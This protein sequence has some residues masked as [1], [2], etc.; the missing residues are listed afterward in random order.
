MKGQKNHNV[1]NVIQPVER[2]TQQRVPSS[3]FSPLL[4]KRA[5][6]LFL[7]RGGKLTAAGGE[8]HPEVIGHVEQ[9]LSQAAEGGQKETHAPVRRQASLSRKHTHTHTRTHAHKHTQTHT[10]NVFV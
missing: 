5:A 8:A 2:N 3:L 4:S 1:F 9:L 6:G 7:L 10:R